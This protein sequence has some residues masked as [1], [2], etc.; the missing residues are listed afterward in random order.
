MAYE[1]M[2]NAGAMDKR[3]IVILND[4]D[5]SIAPPVGALSA[6]LARITSSQTYLQ[7]ARYRQADR[8][9]PAEV[10]G[11]A[12]PAPRSS[13]ATCSLAARCSRSWAFIM[14]A[15]ST[16][17]ISIT[18]CPSCAMSAMPMSGRSWCMSSRK[19]ARAMRRP[20]TRRDKYHGVNKFNVITGAQAKS[21]S[22]APSYT[23]VFAQSPDRGGAQ[24]RQDR[25]HHGGHAGRHRARSFAAAF[26]DRCFDVGIAEQHAVRSPPGL[27]S[28]ASSRS[29]RSIPPSCSA[30][31][32]RS[33]M[34]W[35]CSICPCASQS[36]A[37]ALWARTAPTHAGSFDVA[38]LACLP[39]F[40]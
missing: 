31:M 11:S 22:N 2:N 23:K 34:M 3:L 33:C 25:G 17:T 21:K 30:P 9:E 7:S 40:V 10:P 4:N 6:Y 5:M 28:R 19:R 13:P 27:P 38:Y 35:P 18:C 32:I 20:S 37:P 8:P 15:R 14:S 36:T 24:G 1:A 39:G 29:A 16:A 12:P 26:P